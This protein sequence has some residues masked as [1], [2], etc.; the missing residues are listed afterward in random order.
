MSLI[1]FVNG[2]IRALTEGIDGE[3]LARRE[4]EHLALE[5]EVVSGF[6]AAQDAPVR[7]AYDL[8][9]KIVQLKG[10]VRVVEDLLR[11]GGW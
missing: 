1:R 4:M 2:A 5:G 11:H 3:S 7:W 6:R 8:N 10:I 9:T